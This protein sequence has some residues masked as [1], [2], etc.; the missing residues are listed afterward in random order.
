MFESN[1]ITSE[2]DLSKNLFLSVNWKELAQPDK[3]KR[4]VKCLEV[5]AKSATFHLKR[6]TGI[7]LLSRNKDKIQRPPYDLKTATISIPLAINVNMIIFTC[8]KS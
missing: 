2:E 8:I 1:V 7:A 4:I 6:N 3:M 5:N